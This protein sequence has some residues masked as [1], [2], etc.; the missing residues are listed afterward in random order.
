M[1]RRSRR[2]A[3]G[4]NNFTAPPRKY[5]R[6]G[7][8]G[9]RGSPTRTCERWGFTG[10][11]VD[12]LCA[13]KGVPRCEQGE[14][15]GFPSGAD[16]AKRGKR[17]GQ[18]NQVRDG[19]PAQIILGTASGVRPPHHCKNDGRGQGVWGLA[20]NAPEGWANP[21]RSLHGITPRAAVTCTRDHRSG[22]PV[23][24]SVRNEEPLLLPVSVTINE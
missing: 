8:E 24:H 4:D 14:Q 11:G 3:P 18:N 1:D 5:P 22:I 7:T 6:E 17:S 12:E 19:S 20:R 13:S 9:S 2:P 21:Q 10:L 23:A 16:E 15:W